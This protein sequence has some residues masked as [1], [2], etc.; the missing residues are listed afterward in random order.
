MPQDSNFEE[1]DPDTDL[2]NEDRAI[3]SVLG[4]NPRSD[5]L[6]LLIQALESKRRAILRDAERSTN[7]HER[8]RLEARLAEMSIQLDALRQE[9]A[10]TTF[11]E[12]SVRVTINK[13]PATPD[14]DDFDPYA[15]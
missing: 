1:E 12:N 4:E 9:A 6:L 14:E 3:E 8:I 7:A 2:P 10:I 5:E 13:A 15:E 11:V